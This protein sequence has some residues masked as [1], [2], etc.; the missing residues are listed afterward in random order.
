M[1]QK[2]REAQ[3]TGMESVVTSPTPP[4][5]GRYAKSGL[6][7]QTRR[8]YAGKLSELM[9]VNKPY[10][11]ADLRLKDL[12]ELVNLPAHQLSQVL[13]QEL[14]KKF[15]HYINGFRVAEAKKLLDARREE[16]TILQIAYAAGFNSKNSFNRAFKNI[17]GLSPS[18]YLSRVSSDG[19]GR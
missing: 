6:N 4:T 2:T 3:K 19:P 12:A 10:L 15:T 8:V 17:T 14:G 13:N 16:Q 7:L 9:E 1:E 5:V 11:R 18:A